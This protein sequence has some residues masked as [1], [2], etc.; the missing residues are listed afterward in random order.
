[1]IDPRHPLYLLALASLSLPQPPRAQAAKP[2]S[3]TVPPA[4][5]ATRPQP[6]HSAA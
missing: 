3:E 4:E 6:E 2:A 1:M 5:A